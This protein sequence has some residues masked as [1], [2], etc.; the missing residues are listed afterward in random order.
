[1]RMATT[2]SSAV[3]GTKNT[4]PP[5]RGDWVVASEPQISFPPHNPPHFKGYEN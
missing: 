4:N 5:G 1:M 2:F 3:T